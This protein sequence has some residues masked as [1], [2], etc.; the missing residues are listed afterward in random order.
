MWSRIFMYDWYLK[1][2]LSRSLLPFVPAGPDPAGTGAGAGIVEWSVTDEMKLGGADLSHSGAHVDLALD[3]LAGPAS[4]LD[5]PLT[6]LAGGASLPNQGS[7]PV[8]TEVGGK[9]TI[10]ESVRKITGKKLACLVKVNPVGDRRTRSH[11]WQSASSPQT[12]CPPGK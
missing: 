8:L 12:G 11:P 10:R 5:S 6:I 2:W 4:G 7:D 9:L 1:P 3:L